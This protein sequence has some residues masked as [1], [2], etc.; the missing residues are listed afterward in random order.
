MKTAS[1]LAFLI[2]NK[3]IERLKY[4]VKIENMNYFRLGILDIIKFTRL[5]IARD[6]K[7]TAN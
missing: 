3:Y 2:K 4:A 7:L 6:D 1:I 5:I